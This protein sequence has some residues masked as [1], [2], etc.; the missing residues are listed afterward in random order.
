MQSFN[1]GKGASYLRGLLDQHGGNVLTTLG[2]YNGMEVGAKAVSTKQNSIDS[3]LTDIFRAHCSAVLLAG[4]PTSTSKFYPT[5]DFNSILTV[6]ITSLQQTLNGY[7]Q[8]RDPQ[9]NPR[10]GVYHN[11]DKCQG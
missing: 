1:I 4:N 7:I 6:P 3:D 5:K 2:G 10:L 8:G 9:N 11:Y